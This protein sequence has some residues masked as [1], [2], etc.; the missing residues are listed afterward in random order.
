MEIIVEQGDL[1]QK[2]VDAIVNPANSGGRMGGCVAGVIRRVGGAVIEEEAVKQAPIPIGKAVLTT[3]GALPCKG[4][5][6]APTMVQPAELATAEAVRKAT[7]GALRCAEGAGLSSIA[8]PGMGTGVG[9]LPVDVAAK[10]MVQV[11]RAF[12]AKKLTQAYLIGFEKKMV[13]A[14]QNAVKR[15]S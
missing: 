7:E 11:I 2:K 14:F 15:I 5:I 3:A 12:P 10:T 9:R 4:V 13:D 8:F 1:T 6:H